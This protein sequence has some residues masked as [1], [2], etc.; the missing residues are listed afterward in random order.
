MGYTGGACEETSCN[1]NGILL[2]EKCYCY[3]EYTGFFC[4]VNLLNLLKVWS[5]KGELC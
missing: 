1:G 2:H 5:K 4:L 3:K